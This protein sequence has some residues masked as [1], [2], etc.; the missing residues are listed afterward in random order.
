MI[1]KTILTV[2]KCEMSNYAHAWKLKSLFRI[3]WCL[4]KSRIRFSNRYHYNIHCHICI[5][6]VHI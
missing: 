6:Y 4:P 2:Q 5:I 3:T 1:I